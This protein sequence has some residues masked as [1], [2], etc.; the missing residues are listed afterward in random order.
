MSWPIVAMLTQ[1]LLGLESI[2]IKY[3]QIFRVNYTA[4]ISCMVKYFLYIP[5]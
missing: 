3:V 5:Q 2:R 4:F 1:N